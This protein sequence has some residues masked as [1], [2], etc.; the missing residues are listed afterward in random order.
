[1]LKATRYVA[2]TT[3]TYDHLARTDSRSC[4][5]AIGFPRYLRGLVEL[6]E[7]A[8]R[9]NLKIITVTD[10][11][12]SALRGDINLCA[13]AESAS[14]VAAH[15]APLIL[16]NSLLHEVSLLDKTRTLNALNRFEALAD[17]QSYFHQS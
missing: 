6:L 10:S 13:P 9:K 3:E 5:V 7:Y 1:E 8:R 15:C 17:D 14:F 12:F 2:I 11:P 4:L 16:I